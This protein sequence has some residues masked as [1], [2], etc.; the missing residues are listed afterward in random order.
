[1]NLFIR[2]FWLSFVAMTLV[3]FTALHAWWTFQRSQMA[4]R[5]PFPMTRDHY[6]AAYGDSGYTVHYLYLN[7]I[8]GMQKRIQQSD[9]LL[10]GP[11]HV[12]LGLSAAQLS[13]ELTISVGR[14]VRVYNLGIG[15]GDSLPFDKDVLAANNIHHK[16]AIID[17]YM[18]NGEDISLF[19]RKV[20]ATSGLGAYLSVSDLWLRAADDW[21]LDPWLPSFSLNSNL[22]APE[23]KPARMLESFMV[24]SW[25]TGDMMN[26]WN[27]NNGFIFVQ[28]PP[29]SNNPFS[30]DDPLNHDHAHDLTLT[31]KMETSLK[32]R[33]IRPIYTLIPYDGY[34]PNEIPARAKPYIPIPSNNL[35]FLDTN[36][37]N[38]SSRE[39]ATERL[40]NGIKNNG[41]ISPWLLPP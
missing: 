40:F 41:N 30:Q 3:S 27:P 18:P 15:Y 4:A 7:G 39:I 25:D 23:I 11:S 34:L 12:E 9:V 37:L 32:E 21:L 14:P 16:A 2:F 29:A 5:P 26:I 36:H 8:F 22:G 28:S 19:A 6:I 17:L 35:T 13:Q 1:M 20:E 10:L 38:A 31:A 24:R 33:D